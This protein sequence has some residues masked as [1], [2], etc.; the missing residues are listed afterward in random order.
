MC[1]AAHSAWSPRAA[2][3][4]LGSRMIMLIKSA[5][6]H[7]AI[8]AVI[9][10]LLRKAWQTSGECAGGGRNDYPAGTTG[11]AGTTW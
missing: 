9:D 8:A 4:W 11:P 3:P 7:G 6:A 5:P 10:R 2:T 1:H